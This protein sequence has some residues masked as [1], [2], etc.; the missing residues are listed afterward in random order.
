MDF[1]LLTFQL[2]IFGQAFF[3][4]SWLTLPFIMHAVVLKSFVIHLEVLQISVVV[5]SANSSRRRIRS[6]SLSSDT[7]CLRLGDVA[8]EEFPFLVSTMSK[9]KTAPVQSTACI[10]QPFR[11]DISRARS[12]NCID[13]CTC[14][15]SD[16][17]GSL[18]AVERLSTGL[19][20]GGLR[21]NQLPDECRLKVFSFLS[22]LD[23]GIAAQVWTCI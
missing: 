18:L 1:L 5:M 15:S 16:P 17:D 8:G 2:M 21:F 7:E 12:S 3:C 23:R 4:S 20:V 11:S 10:K 9:P 13:H 14:G 22:I 19:T 6:V